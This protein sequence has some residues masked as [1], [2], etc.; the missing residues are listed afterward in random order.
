MRA[1]ARR[2]RVMLALD[3]RHAASPL[4]DLDHASGMRGAMRKSLR[5]D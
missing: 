3:C 2:G 1:L 4:L 5:C